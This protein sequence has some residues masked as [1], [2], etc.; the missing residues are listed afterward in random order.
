[1]KQNE[2]IL[3]YL[4][5]GFLAVILVVAVTFGRDGGKPDVEQREDTQVRDL[6]EFFGQDLGVAKGS[7]A[8]ANAAQGSANVRV[9][10][11]G[12]QP[13]VASQPTP[14]AQLLAQ[15]LGE[16][17]TV[18]GGYRLVKARAGDSLETLVH[19]WCGAR[20]QYL[21]EAK[22]LNE[23]LVI[24]HP[25]QEVLL[26]GVADEDVWAAYQ[27]RQPHLLAPETPV[28][29]ASQPQPAVLNQGPEFR[30]PGAT[31]AA[32]P[33][34]GGVAPAVLTA[35]GAGRVHVVKAGESLWKIAADLVGASKADKCIAEIR[36]LNSGLQG[37]RINVGQK[38][39]VPVAL[40]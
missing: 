9:P 29:G 34:T 30:M 4:V 13:L 20:A 25:G 10:D 38:L 17:K 31:E 21:D 22:A 6:R 14:A 27:A 26:P 40:P 7:V 35:D 8:D 1:M 39:V 3:V 12:E 36:K 2:R 11:A 18:H 23:S 28:A 37:D 15:Y 32:G 24:L 5:M 19:R 16:S 33:G